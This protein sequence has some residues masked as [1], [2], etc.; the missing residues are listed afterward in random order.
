MRKFDK[1]LKRIF[2][3]TGAA[4]VLIIA[5]LMVIGVIGLFGN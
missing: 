3:Y 5:I 1:W 2:F 4:M